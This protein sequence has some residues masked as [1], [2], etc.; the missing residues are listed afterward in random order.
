MPVWPK[1]VGDGQ[2][3]EGTAL[4]PDRVPE[5]VGQRFSLGEAVGVVGRRPH[6]ADDGIEGIPGVDVKVT[7]PGLAHGARGALSRWR[8]VDG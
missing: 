7:E 5:R 4:E 6:G 8:F 2:E 1:V 3:V